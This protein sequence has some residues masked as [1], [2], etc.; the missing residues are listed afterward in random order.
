MVTNV[1]VFWGG[2]LWTFGLGTGQK[3]ERE[4]G[5]SGGKGAGAFRVHRT[6]GRT[7]TFSPLERFTNRRLRRLLL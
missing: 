2:F 1:Y 4:R 6:R 5:V 3:Q 7:L